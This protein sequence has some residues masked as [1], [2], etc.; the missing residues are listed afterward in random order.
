MPSLVRQSFRLGFLVAMLGLPLS[1]LAAQS[2]TIQGQVVDSAGAPIVGAIV[3]VDRTSLGAT[4]TASGRYTLHGVPARMVTLTVHAIG[5]AAASSSVTVVET[6]VVEVNFTMNRSPVELAP[7][8]VVVG[9][10]AH[11][12][13]AE[14]LAV[15]VD[16][17][18]AEDIQQQG[19]TETSQVL[20][21]LSPSVNFPRQSVTDA[22]DIVR[23]FTLRGLSP[24]HTLVLVNGWRRHQMAV[25]NTFAYGMGAGSSGVDLNA[26][27]GGAIDRIEVLGTAPPPSTAPTQSRASST[28]S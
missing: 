11:H 17:Y 18:T 21:T 25:L 28:S 4:T 7:I 9:S 23:P 27:P 15:P 26:I 20:Q 6:D 3:S 19:T 24:D 14:E 10:R 16:V 2:G 5:F 22:N 1:D 13:A 8:D 12:T